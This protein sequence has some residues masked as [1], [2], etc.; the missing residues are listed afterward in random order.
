MLYNS[1]IHT[2]QHERR[3]TKGV[4]HPGT[5]PLYDHH[6]EETT[7]KDHILYS[8]TATH[9]LQVMVFTEGLD[10]TGITTSLVRFSMYNAA[11]GTSPSHGK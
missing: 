3:C 7:E 5:A 9:N 2:K 11:N 4:Y 8:N 10:R 6:P 1:L